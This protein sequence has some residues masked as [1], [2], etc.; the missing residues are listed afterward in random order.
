MV[1]IHKITAISWRVNNAP[2]S[3]RLLFDEVRRSLI[4]LYDADEAAALAFRLI[5]HHFDLDRSRVL[6]GRLLPP[7]T[8][9]FFSEHLERLR[10]GEPLQYV[11]GET[12]FGG[13]LLRTD[14]RA[15]IPRPE[16]EEL[17]DWVLADHAHVAGLKS[18][19]VGTGSGAIALSLAHALVDARVMGLDVST[20]ALAL[21]RENTDRLGVEVEWHE[22]DV[23]W[24]DRLPEAH[25]LDLLVSNPPYVPAAEAALM[26]T[27]VRDH[28]PPAALFVPDDDPLL[29]YRALARFGR[30]HLR[31]GGQM[32]VEM[33]ERFG[34]AVADL[35]RSAGYADV[36]V[37]RDAYGRTRMGRATKAG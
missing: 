31:P 24:P 13:H 22:W 5:A 16:T 4:P 23:L 36:C 17:V 9:P 27:N 21:A 32:Y 10:R 18:I 26:H 11:L 6:G 1:E 25:A 2:T 15:L 34:D 28:E 35:L 37:R 30:D 12:G 14:A 33:H 7:G 20:D 8:S 3:S 19:D 29:F